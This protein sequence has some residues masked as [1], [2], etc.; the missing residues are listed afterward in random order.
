MNKSFSF[1]H[2]T[3]HYGLL[4]GLFLVLTTL[5]LYLSELDKNNFSSLALYAVLLGSIIWSIT[6]SKS[7][8]QGHITFSEGFKSGFYTSLTAVII[9]TLYFFIHI[10]FID[11][12]FITTI[13]KN[14]IKE[15]KMKGLGEAEIKK[16]L[17]FTEFMTQAPVFAALEGFN[18]LLSSVIFSLI[19]AGVFK[20]KEG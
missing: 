5:I 20:S 13:T 7:K 9:Q 18:L 19:A 16:A 11:K 15:M 8:N 6:D 4:S 2:L 10:S 3:I 14:K 1:T 12:S 17:E